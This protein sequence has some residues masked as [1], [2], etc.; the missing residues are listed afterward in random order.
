MRPG[1]CRPVGTAVG[2]AAARWVGP[3]P[4]APN[5]PPAVEGTRVLTPAAGPVR[6]GTRGLPGSGLLAKDSLRPIPEASWAGLPEPAAVGLPIPLGGIAVTGLRG[7]ADGPGVVG[8]AALPSPAGA[9]APVKSGR[10]G[11]LVPG[12][13]ALGGAAVTIGSPALVTTFGGTP[14]LVGSTAR[15]GAPTRGT[16]GLT[17]VGVGATIP[18]R[19]GPVAGGA[20]STG[21]AGVGAGTWVGGAAWGLGGSAAAASSSAASSWKYFRT[22]SAAA[23]S[24][25]L[26]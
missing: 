20:G 15:G 13:P 23:S 18:G 21:L 14:A 12:P 3:S 4:S 6:P 1:T 7:P 22:F 10:G 9:R 26:E 17:P 5:L 8:R 16:T 2:A 24:I 25:E 11:S 19:V